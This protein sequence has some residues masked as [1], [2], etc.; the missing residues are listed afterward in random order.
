MLNHH[1]ILKS[2]D[3]TLIEV[4]QKV[5]SSVRGCRLSVLQGFDQCLAEIEDLN[6][7]LLLIHLD[8]LSQLERVA[9]ITRH[10]AVVRRSVAVI[11]I[12][13]THDGETAAALLRQGVADVLSRPLDLR[14]LNFLIDSLSLRARYSDD[15]TPA[16]A[17]NSDE[18][19]SS[20]RAGWLYYGSRKT[21]TIVERIDRVAKTEATVLLTGE[22]G[23]GKSRF[24]QLIHDA[25][26]RS[27][28]PL[29]VVNCAALPPSLIESE[30]FGHRKGAFSG[31]ETDRDGRFAAAGKGTILLDDIDALPLEIQ[32]KLLRVVDDRVFEP[33]GSNHSL[34]L[35]ARIVAATNRNLA[36]EVEQGR[37]RADV[38]YRLNVIH[39]ELP[40]VR[41]RREDILPL[42]EGFLARIAARMQRPVPALSFGIRRLVQAY[43]WPGN[44]RQIRNA[45]EHALT[46]CRDNVVQL[47]DLPAEL[48]AF[49]GSSGT[50]SP[51]TGETSRETSVFSDSPS[52]GCSTPAREGDRSEDSAE[53][54]DVDS[55]I[56]PWARGLSS[57]ARARVK[58]EIKR[59]IATLNRTG[60]NRSQAARELGISRVALYKKL[61]KYG[62][63]SAVG[64]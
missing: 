20:S 64:K 1:V 34:P 60:N 61:H 11:V 38:Y 24:G 14:R 32:G 55:A 3:A 33:V 5:V 52:A 30:L 39:F 28:E 23:T 35:R 53:L 29:L 43:D 15:Q 8:D 2:Q 12:A 18:S 17:S 10:N 37:F 40:P 19:L 13:E 7:A 45:A 16:V 59:I 47:D 50:I 51:H 58:G 4:T 27:S 21:S 44:I 62:L 9:A 41:E 42:F 6:S 36:K 26:P 22:T 48:H 63:M 49:A 56:F 25:S 57:L 46:L 31:A 54:S